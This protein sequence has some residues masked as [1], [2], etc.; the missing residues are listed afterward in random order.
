MNKMKK[1]YKYIVGAL[2]LGLTMTACSPEEFSGADQNG[3]PTVDGVNMTWNV[4]A[5]TNQ[6]T[7]SVPEMPGVYPLWYI[8]W[9]N[10]KGEEQTFYSTLDSISKQFVDAGDYDITL[11]LGNK[12]GFSQAGITKT[13]H[14]PKSLVD[15][16]PFYTKLSNK[17]WRIDHAEKGHVGCGPSG[18][19]GTSWWA[20]GSNELKASGVYDDR[21]TFTDKGVYTYDPG[22]DG[23]TFVNKGT[24]IWPE[25]NG[26]KATEDK[27]TATAA[28]TSTYVL[29]TDLYTPNGATAKVQGNYITLGPKT[30][31]PYISDDAQYNNAKMRIESITN[32]KL[33]LVYDKPD[34]S[35]AWHYILTS[36]PDSKVFEGYDPAS[37]C[38]MWK[39]ATYTLAQYYA[40]GS[41]WAANPDPIVISETSKC[42]YSITLPDASDQQW[43]AQVKFKSDL[44]TN[45]ATNYD[46]S[47]CLT[48]SKDIKGA[49]I[50]F[51][52]E[53]DDN[54]YLGI[55]RVDLVAGQEYVYYKSDVAGKDIDKLSLVLDFGG[56]PAGTTVDVNNLVF[57]EHSCDDGTV[58]P[59]PVVKMDWTYDSPKNLWKPYDDSK[60]APKFWFANSGWAQIADPTYSQE[61]DVHIVTMPIATEAQWQGQMHFD[62]DMTAAMADKYNF[63]CVLNS[64]QDHPGVTIKLTEADDSKKHDD[65]FFF[66]PRVALSAGVDYIFKAKNVSLPKN[67]AHALNLFF[68]F[69]GNAAGTTVKVSKIYFEKVQ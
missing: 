44:A 54:T 59:A 60:L 17:E 50:K 56:A 20:A 35:I 65:N 3:L 2:F 46:Y 45:A 8:H 23:K 11:R 40:N 47:V 48:P 32:K 10:A 16:A 57:K 43:Q 27:N 4:D 9:Y 28:Q 63:Y 7:A 62:T 53:G 19:D 66:A 69:G 41:G 34:G 13:A 36:D 39:D 5:E 67:D 26:G 1:T 49:T 6:V 64:D 24:T 58:L 31:F 15:W 55:D 38:N 22:K 37:K 33:V 42:N 12:N 29:S 18:T 21:I 25:T 52:K 61:G 68:D 51:Y 30:L 14:F